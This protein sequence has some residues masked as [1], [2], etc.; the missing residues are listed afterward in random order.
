MEHC[1]KNAPKASGSAR[2]VSASSGIGA[3]EAGVTTVA[4]VDTS[5]S[6]SFDELVSIAVNVDE[7]AEYVV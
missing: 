2:G 1:N 4:V 3:S 7:N 5:V 6:I